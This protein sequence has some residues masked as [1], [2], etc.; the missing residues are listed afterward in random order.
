MKKKQKGVLTLDFI[1]SFFTVYG[2]VLIFMYLAF[3]FMTISVSQ[4]I[5]F[6]TMRAHIAGHKDFASQTIAGQ[7]QYQKIMSKYQSVISSSQ[8]KWVK[9]QPIDETPR[10][11]QSEGFNWTGAGGSRQM[12][13]GFG[14]SYESS[15]LK[16]AKLPIIGGIASSSDEF[17]KGNLYTFLY[18]EVTASECLG[19]TK[20]RWDA[21][22]SRFPSLQSYSGVNEEV[23]VQ[24]DNGC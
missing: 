18:R 21:I 20:S 6:T 19:F 4:Y 13:Y 10:S 9:L 12:P 7:R 15:L 16:N 24:A 23:P 2:F 11:Y 8:G 14:V 22:K 5:T 17:G 1:F 3:S